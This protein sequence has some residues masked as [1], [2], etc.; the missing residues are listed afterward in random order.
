MKTRIMTTTLKKEVWLSFKDNN[1]TDPDYAYRS[2]KLNPGDE[3]HVRV[4]EYEDGRIYFAYF[5]LKDENIYSNI[6]MKK[7][8]K[9]YKNTGIITYYDENQFRNYLN[10]KN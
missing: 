9:L 3:C 1:I 10:S 8:G 4:S 2:I 7:D 6:S 5:M